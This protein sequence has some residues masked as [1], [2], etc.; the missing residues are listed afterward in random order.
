M[1]RKKIL[2]L[3]SWYPGKFE[4]FNGDF[5]QRHAQAAALYHDI[6]VLH[7]YGESG[8][9]LRKTEELS[10]R[11]DHLS[12]QIIYFP[13]KQGGPG[14]LWAAYRW[15][16]LSRYAIKKYVR[17]Q[18]IPDLVHVHVPMK[19]GIFGIWM[20]RKYGVEYCV[21]EHWGIYN[22]SVPDPFPRR[23][24]T[25]KNVTRKIFRHA[26]RALSPSEFL[27]RGVD[28]MVMKKQWI[29][30][31]NVVNTG[32]FNLKP[33]DNSP[34]FRFIH[35]SNMIALKNPEG[36]LRA[37]AELLKATP[38]AELV[39][40]GDKDPSIRLTATQLGIHDRVR[41]TGEITYQEVAVE[42]KE[43]DCLVLFSDMENSPCVIGEALC[44]GLPVI[45]TRVGG[46]PELVNESNGIL[47]SPRDTN[48]LE[49]A[50]LAM[51]KTGDRFDPE[52]ISRAATAKF[53]YPV[54][55]KQFDDLYSLS[56]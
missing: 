10:N 28:E 27:A 16:F 15:L 18:G 7:V 42:M 22:H 48:A 12:E 56:Y 5:I 51:I 8:G 35:V 26:Q 41:F 1:P 33:K 43:A 25:F 44:C 55:G 11:H 4:P 36:I 54:V 20:K 9:A 3:C 39:M 50:M 46:I 23:N 14:K 40:V 6:H 21:T 45:A 38:E 2:W 24:S 31:P 29:I 34:G 53:S 17:E 13:K 49:A 19:A 30:I 47:V 52:E 32:L 37:F